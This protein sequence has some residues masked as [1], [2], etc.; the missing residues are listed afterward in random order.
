[1]TVTIRILSGPQE[2]ILTSFD[3]CSN[4]DIGAR[5]TAQAIFGH[6]QWLLVAFCGGT[7]AESDYCV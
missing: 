3:K 5:S 2:S 6:S 1:M 7:S 4:R